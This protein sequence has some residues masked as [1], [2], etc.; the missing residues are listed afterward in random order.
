MARFKIIV[1]Q[2]AQENKTDAIDF[3]PDVKVDEDIYMT[4]ITIGIQDT[5]GVI[6]DYSI[7]IEVIHNN[8]QTGYEVDEQRKKE[9]KKA[10]NKLN[11]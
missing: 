7:D 11:K 3:H 1:R 10:I 6:P 2:D 9:I 5:D 8:S 4:K